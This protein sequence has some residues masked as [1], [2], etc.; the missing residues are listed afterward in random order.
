MRFIWVLKFTLLLL[1]FV[2]VNVLGELGPTYG[3]NG[4]WY[5]ARLTWYQSYPKEGSEECIKY[6]GCEHA[7]YFAFLGYQKSREWVEENNIIAVHSEHTK[8]LGLKKLRLRED[9]ENEDSEIVGTVYDF[10]SDQD[11]HGCCTRNAKESGYLVD[12]EVST[13][14]RMGYTKDSYPEFIYFMVYE[15]KKE[16]LKREMREIKKEIRTI[17]RAIKKEEKILEKTESIKK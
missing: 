15:T 9:P 10:C 4:V 17:D 11:C 2:Y 14:K 1:P 5:K 16:K 12:L 3:K 7:G 6:N 13:L 8:W